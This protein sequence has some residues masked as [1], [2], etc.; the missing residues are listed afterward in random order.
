MKNALKQAIYE[1]AKD[2]Y[3]AG[4]ISKGRMNEYKKLNI[5]AAHEFKPEDIK[6][7]RGKGKVLLIMM[8]VEHAV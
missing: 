2:L 4:L 6:T 1:T 7:L 3:E 8:E 5:P